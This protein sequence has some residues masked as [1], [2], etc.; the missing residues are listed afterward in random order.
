MHL[1]S[2]TGTRF[3]VSLYRWWPVF[4]LA[5]CI[6][7]AYAAYTD[8]K[9]LRFKGTFNPFKALELPKSKKLPS[10]DNLK[11]AFRKASLK[12]HPD[13]CR[14]KGEVSVE[15]CEKRMEDVHLAQEVLS[16][17]RKLQQ[18][19]AWDEDRRGGPKPQDGGRTKPFG[20]PFGSGGGDDGGIPESAF[21]AKF[22]GF[23]GFNFGGGSS[24][25]TRK[26]KRKRPPTPPP[27]P[28]RRSASSAAPEGTKWKIVSREKRPGMKGAEVEIVTRER[29]LPGTPMIQVETVERTCYKAQVQCQESVL[30]RRRRRRDEGS[31]AE[32]L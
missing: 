5:S 18:W 3:L 26:P 2:S 4:A 23:P 6:S 16:D 1:Q 14:R 31:A 30:E 20:Q 12:W 24:G 28:P 8:A 27:T 22:Q 9:P 19:E 13:R 21:G 17:E 7:P 11:K 29:D 10:A 25:G 15:E 32:E